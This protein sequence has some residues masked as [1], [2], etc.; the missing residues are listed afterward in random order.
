M[1]R[2]SYFAGFI[3]GALSVVLL[4]ALFSYVEEVDRRAYER[5]IRARCAPIQEEGAPNVDR[6]TAAGDDAERD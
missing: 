3:T 6:R 5:L 1:N 2:E 4:S